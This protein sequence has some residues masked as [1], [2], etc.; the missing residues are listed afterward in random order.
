MKKFFTLFS[1]VASVAVFTACGNSIQSDAGKMADKTCECAG[2]AQ[3]LS[4]ID[5]IQACANELIQM[6]KDLDKKYTTEEDQKAFKDAYREA[7]KSCNVQG[8]DELIG[9]LDSFDE[10]VSPD[11]PDS[12][13][14]LFLD[15]YEDYDDFD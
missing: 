5:Q 2:L 4:D 9:V 11:D 1:L 14:D 3:D 13:S 6:G 15:D 8:V 12:D 7:L 10:N